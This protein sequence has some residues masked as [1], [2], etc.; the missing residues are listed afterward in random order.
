MERVLMDQGRLLEMGRDYPICLSTF[1]WMQAKGS[2][3]DVKAVEGLF[4]DDNGHT[5]SVP[6]T[7]EES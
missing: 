6:G 4:R 7:G 1:R 2:E 3:K 5:E